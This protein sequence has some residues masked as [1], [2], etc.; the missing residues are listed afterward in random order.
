M[1]KDK[2]KEKNEMNAFQ[3]SFRP[4]L[5]YKWNSKESNFTVDG[6][7]NDSVAEDNQNQDKNLSI[8]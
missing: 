4:K 7:N 8:N 3:H 2:E 6:I 1:I 5:S